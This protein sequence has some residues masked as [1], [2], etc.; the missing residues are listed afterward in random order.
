MFLLGGVLGGVAFVQLG[1]YALFLPA[2]LSG[3]NLHTVVWS[4]VGATRIC[5]HS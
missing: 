4:E 3:V 5:F 2:S 1:A